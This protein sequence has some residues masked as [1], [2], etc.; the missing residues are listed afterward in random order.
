MSAPEDAFRHAILPVD[1]KQ[2]CLPVQSRE[3][4]GEDTIVTVESNY[5]IFSPYC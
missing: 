1:P 2:S 4:D 5:S 3:L